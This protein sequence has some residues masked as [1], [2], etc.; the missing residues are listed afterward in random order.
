M[1]D[2]R[3]EANQRADAA[4]DMHDEL[5]RLTARVGEL[6]RALLPFANY[7]DTRGV[8]TKDHV[9][10]I[11][12]PLARRQLTMGDCYAAARALGREMRGHGQRE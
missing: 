6:E 7:A 12:S 9:V 11:G 8:I 4:A 1:S 2:D 3:F 5:E 10:T